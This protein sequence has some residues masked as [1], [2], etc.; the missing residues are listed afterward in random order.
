MNMNTRRRMLEAL[1]SFATEP[2][3]IYQSGD[4]SFKNCTHRSETYEGLIPGAIYDAVT[5]S[6]KDKY[7]GIVPSSHQNAHD[8]IYYFYLDVTRYRKIVVKALRTTSGEQDTMVDPRVG[9]FDSDGLKR[10]SFTDE[11]SKEVTK[12]DIFGFVDPEELV[13]DVTELKGT[14]VLAFKEYNWSA[15]A[16][17]EIRME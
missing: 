11:N 12:H 17:Y 1:S 7:F 6:F 2:L 16:Y 14:K 4:T 15:G 10:S 9:V 13:F 5:I 3:Y 8:T